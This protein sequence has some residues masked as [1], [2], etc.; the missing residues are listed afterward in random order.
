MFRQAISAFQAIQ[1]CLFGTGTI[2]L[3]TGVNAPLAT[4]TSGN[5]D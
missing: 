2:G 3:N 5:V 1:V 4:G